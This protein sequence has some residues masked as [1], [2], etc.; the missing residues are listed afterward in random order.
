MGHLIKNFKCKD[1]TGMAWEEN[2]I[3]VCSRG[4]QSP[5]TKKYRRVQ[6]RTFRS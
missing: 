1:K 4:E 2:F 5:S 6:S 3:E